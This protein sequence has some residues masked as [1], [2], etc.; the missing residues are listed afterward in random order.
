MQKAQLSLIFNHVKLCVIFFVN[1]ANRSIICPGGAY[2]VWT[3]CVFSK[4]LL[5]KESNFYNDLSKKT[6]FFFVIL[7]SVIVTVFHLSI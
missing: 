3:S 2:L 5:I 6:M 1:S 4:V 7:P